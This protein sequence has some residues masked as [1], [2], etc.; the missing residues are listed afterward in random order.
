MRGNIIK[1]EELSRSHYENNPST[2]FFSSLR[3]AIARRIYRMPS[4]CSCLFCRFH[5][6]KSVQK[7]SHDLARLYQVQRNSG[8]W[9]VYHRRWCFLRIWPQ[10]PIWGH[11]KQLCTDSIENA[12]LKRVSFLLMYVVFF[13]FFYKS[14]CF[15]YVNLN[16][17]SFV[18]I[19]SF[20]MKSIH[21]CLLPFSWS[22]MLYLEIHGQ[23][24]DLFLFFIL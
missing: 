22:S 6:S 8:L 2:T 15:L 9:Y 5:I 13:F 17:Q 19:I 4:S 3:A 20:N 21:K 16:V 1:L 7:H 14:L 24:T 10:T 12:S 23:T 18:L 11:Y